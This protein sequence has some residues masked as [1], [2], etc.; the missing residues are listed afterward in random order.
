[1]ELTIKHDMV[2]IDGQVIRQGTAVSVQRIYTVNGG[3][4]TRMDVVD[5]SG[6]VF[7]VAKGD[8]E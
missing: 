6:R 3:S 4:E 8:V 5:S 2:T 1:M 7:T